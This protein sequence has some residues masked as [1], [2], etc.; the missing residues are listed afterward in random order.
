MNTKLLL[1][2]S[3]IFLWVHASRADDKPLTGDMAKIQGTWKGQT[4][5]DGQF[6]TVMTLKGNTGKV[7]NTTSTGDKIGLAYKF[8]IDDKAKPY[9]T[10]RIYDIV[11]YGG[12][13]RGPEQV[14]GIYEFVDANTIRF[15][16]GFDGKYPTEFKD[17]EG[18]SSLLF[19]LKRDAEVA[20]TGK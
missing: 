2:L 15:C 4:G 14:Y 7:D 3:L 5:R 6:Q 17:S 18:R 10:I 13:G 19:T 9:K 12:N 16:N 1:A 11:R 8:E 20:E